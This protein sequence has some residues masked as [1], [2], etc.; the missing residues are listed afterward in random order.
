MQRPEEKDERIERQA[1]N[2]REL[3]YENRM[4]KDHINLLETESQEKQDWIEY[5]EGE[6]KYYKHKS[7]AGVRF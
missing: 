3:N 2:I 7:S 4:A 1:E 5:L 6:I